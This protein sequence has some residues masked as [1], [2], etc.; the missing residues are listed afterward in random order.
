M[1]VLFVHQSF[2]TLKDGGSGR[3]NDFA[4]R[5]IE[6]G[7]DVVCLAGT[8]NYLTGE[9]PSSFRGRF[10]I[11][12]QVDGYEVLR[13]WTY[14]GYHRT[15]ASR[16]V[17]FLS[18][19]ASSLIAGMQERRVNLVAPCTPPFFLGITGYLLSIWHRAPLVYEVRDLWSE[20]AFQLG[21]V[22]NPMIIAAVRKLERFL[23]A[24]SRYVVVNSPGFIEPL[25]AIGV[26]AEK[27]KL[28]PNGVDLDEFRPM[29]EARDRV[30]AEFDFGARYVVMYTGSLGLANSLETIIEAAAL[31]REDPQVL[32]V[33][34][35]DGQRRAH[36]EATVREKGLDNVMFTGSVPKQRIAELLAAA[37][38]GIAT[39]LDIPL[40]RTVYPNKVFD[41]MACGRPTVIAIDGVIRDVIDR[42]RGGVFAT[43]E[44][45][46]AIVAGIQF[47]RQ[48]PDEARVMGE[49]ATGFVREHF[50]RR[51]AEVSMAELMEQAVRDS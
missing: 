14:D 50:D 17:T 15:F 4:R 48:H 46:H 37:D 26:P 31:L 20:V 29:P 47:L 5:L 13:T 25:K 49:R 51:A 22:K 21:I 40:F 7:H 28:I 32:F 45:P 27:I 3:A 11:R 19:M 38:V 2:Q 1:R 10:S 34:V 36:L 16:V 30:R 44:D 6:R 39:L 35:G 42:S 43:P 18:F 23:Y 8:F 24:R 33:F 9:V 12:E 41:Y